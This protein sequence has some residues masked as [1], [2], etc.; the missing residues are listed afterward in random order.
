MNGLPFKK[1]SQKS[2]L[3]IQL[4]GKRSLTVQKLEFVKM[5]AGNQQGKLHQ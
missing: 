1:Q 4:P 5:P 2:I 3:Q